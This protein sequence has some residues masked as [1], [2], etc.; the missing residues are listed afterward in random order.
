VCTKITVNAH[1]AMR[2][3]E[4]THDPYFMVRDYDMGEDRETKGQQK[5]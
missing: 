5:T 1:I 4:S 3:Y 2:K